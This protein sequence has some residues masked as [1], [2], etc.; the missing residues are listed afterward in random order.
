MNRPIYTYKNS[1]SDIDRRFAEYLDGKT[2]AIVGRANLHTLEQGEFIDSHDVTV[3]V[4]SVIP[5]TPDNQGIKTVQSHVPDEWKP[6]VGSR[7]DILYH[8]LLSD[9]KK[10]ADTGKIH[11]HLIQQIN[12]FWEQGGRFICHEDPKPFPLRYAIPSLIAEIRYPSLALY[13]HLVVELRKDLVEPGIIAICDVLSHNIKS[14]YITGFPCYF[15]ETRKHRT[16]LSRWDE[17]QDIKELQFLYK[18]SK[19][20]NVTFDPLMINLFEQHCRA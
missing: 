12:E 11:P 18:L 1:E 15:D 7:V 5:Y 19:H 3:R 10:W 2:V 14:A 16:D 9:S 13:A 4:H 17:V 20:D 6:I 8:R